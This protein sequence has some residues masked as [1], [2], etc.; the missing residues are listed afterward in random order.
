MA[1]IQYRP[2]ARREGFNPNKLSTEGISRMREESSRIVQGL[3]ETRA[4]EAKQA[5]INLRAMESDAAY[6]ERITKENN[7]IQLQNLQNR[8][9]QILA[10]IQG[11][12]KQA[13]TD[14]LAAQTIIESLVDFSDTLGK[15]AARRTKQMIEDQTEIGRLSVQALDPQRLEEFI[16]AENARVDGTIMMTGEIAANDAEA[17]VDRLETIKNLVG[18]P[19]LTGYAAQ[20]AMNELSRQ[21]YGDTLQSRLTDSETTYTSSTGVQYTG[22]QASRDVNLV[23]DLQ[24]QTERDVLK[25]LNITE[26]L[27]VRKG[28][29]AIRKYNDAID[30]QTRTRNIE[31]KEE[32]LRQKVAANYRTNTFE[33]F[34]QGFHV[35]RGAFGLKAA[36]DSLQQLV[37]DPSI[38]LDQLKKVKIDGKVWYENWSNRWEAGLEARNKAIA[39]GL[40]IERQLAEEEDKAWVRSSLPSIQEAYDQNATQASLLVRKRYLDKGMPVPQA[41]KNIETAAFAKNK[42]EVQATFEERQRFGILDLPFV[43]S[44]Q[45]PTLQKKAIQAYE[46]QQLNR[47]GSEALG[48]KKGLKAT[49]RKL[50]KIDPNEEQ[51]SATTFLVQA[52]LES[53]YLKELKLTNDPLKALENVNRMVDAAANGDKSSPFFSE[54]GQNNRLIFPNIQTSDRELAEMTTYINKQMLNDGAGVADKPFALAN[55]DQMDAAYASSLVGVTRYPAGILQVADALNLKPSEVYNAQRL[56]NNAATGVNKPLLAPS[57]ASMLIDSAPPAMRKLFLSDTP[58]QINRG[59]RAMKGNLP[60]RSSMGGDFSSQRQALETAAAELGVD[61]IDLATIIGFE[62][63]GTYDPGVVGGQGGNYQGL[64]QFGIPERQA[65]GVVPGMTFE[66]QLLGPVVSY[67]KDR[68]AKVGMSTQGATLEDLYTTVLAGNPMANRDARDSFGT[69]ARSGV[70][71]MFKE[72]RP[73]AIKRFGF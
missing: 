12:Q 38:D 68:F 10:D 29:A 64:I 63:G 72:H 28:L 67:F 44:I 14:S 34:A 57:P 58:A 15:E 46:E 41:I 8:Q 43:N 22:L 39:T 60:R 66:E 26:P 33:G 20:G 19:G 5:E 45:D 71:R 35:T 73:V 3:R 2:S 36:H 27:Q 52:R 37:G 59:G 13:Q 6:T 16:R 24:R 18:I 7:A 50:T 17:G 21:L 48:I 62:T 61:P 40:R 70:E 47:Y 65:Y 31:D 69:S 23:S 1:R 25:F 42:A 4:A 55:S 54:S 53:E 49:A 56:A 32:E 11:E 51:G 30:N 9:N